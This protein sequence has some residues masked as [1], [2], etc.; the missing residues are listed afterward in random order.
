MAKEPKKPEL[1]K[2][3]AEVIVA[4][5]SR[6]QFH[7]EKGVDTWKEKEREYCYEQC[8]ELKS[9][10]FRKWTTDDVK[11]AA[12]NLR[13]KGY[14]GGIKDGRNNSPK[15]NQL[16]KVLDSVAERLGVETYTEMEDE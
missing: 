4:A 2:D 12:S 13:K 15:L 8:M 3:V 11:V 14:I 1:P 16:I 6:T 10:E 7:F 9:I 5:A